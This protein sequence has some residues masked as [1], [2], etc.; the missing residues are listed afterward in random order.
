MATDAAPESS[1]P[2]PAPVGGSV[3]V[4]P[5]PTRPRKLSEEFELI[6]REFELETVTLRE[7]LVLLQGRGYVLLMMLLALPFC[8]PVPLP[9][10]STPFGLIVALIGARLACGVKPWLPEKLLNTRLP[11][12]VFTKVFEFT[13]R[14][15]RAFERLLR[16]RLL[17]LTRTPGRI[18]LHS[19]PV[20]ICALM[21]LLPLPIP[22]SNTIPAWGIL[23]IAGGL[24]E[25]DGLFILGGYVATLLGVAFLVVIWIFGIGAIDFL[26]KW[27][28]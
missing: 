3:I 16:P 21:L 25:R 4:A 27:L 1:P 23:L 9:G 11:P 2:P 6:L 22:F 17:W 24:L 5:D 8:T 20:V 14:I 15:I 10:L 28:K 19:V 7:V 18:Q 12:K 13:R 26:W